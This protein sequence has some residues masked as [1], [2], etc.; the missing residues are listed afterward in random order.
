MF[1]F[2]VFPTPIEG[3]PVKHVIVVSI[4][5]K[6]PPF[7][8]LPLGDRKKMFLQNREKLFLWLFHSSSSPANCSSEPWSLG[9]NLAWG[10]KKKNSF[11]EKKIFFSIGEGRPSCTSCNNDIYIFSPETGSDTKIQ[12]VNVCSC[13]ICNI[14]FGGGNIWVGV[15]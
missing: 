8:L 1:R 6:Q 10:K 15:K 11:G 5:P 9:P 4:Q 14:S 13:R 2:Y 7:F 12:P 3:I